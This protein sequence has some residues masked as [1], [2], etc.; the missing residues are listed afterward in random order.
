M[1]REEH[2]E[3]YQVT[4]AIPIK[5]GLKDRITQLRQANPFVTIAI[6]IKRGLKASPSKVPAP[7]VL[8]LLSRLKG[9]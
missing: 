4:I 7:P 8:Q 2:K 9:D 6:P 1:Q 5:R 3:I